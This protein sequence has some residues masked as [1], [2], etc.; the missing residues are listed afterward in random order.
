[1]KSVA[2]T[3]Q[4]GAITNDVA[5]K[6]LNVSS[7]VVTNMKEAT[8]SGQTSDILAAT[9]EV[10]RGVTEFI[11]SRTDTSKYV[12][13]TVNV[14]KAQ[15][16][17]RELKSRAGQLC[18][19]LTSESAPDAAPVGSASKDFSFSCQ[20]VEERRSR[21]AIG[22]DRNQVGWLYCITWF[23]TRRVYFCLIFYL[24]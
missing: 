6:A 8:S 14:K 20:K 1:M 19:A 17:K 3:V 15:N 24:I 11:N 23:R 4:D 13:N 7:V 10:Y 16:L 9:V 2:T 18:D 12:R 5:A 21:S 22:N